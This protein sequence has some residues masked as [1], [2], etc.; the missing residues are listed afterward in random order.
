MV[1]SDEEDL[2]PHT[3]SPDTFPKSGWDDP[4]QSVV[5]T[6]CSD[7]HRAEGTANQTNPANP[8]N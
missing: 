8:E 1:E 7:I 6:T 2:V 3:R 5:G 4:S